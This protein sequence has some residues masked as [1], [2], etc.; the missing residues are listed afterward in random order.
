MSKKEGSQIILSGVNEKVHAVLEKSGFNDL[1]GKE[2]I[3]SHI[4]IALDRAKEI[5]SK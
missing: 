2:N 4:N 3:C 1:L 5:L